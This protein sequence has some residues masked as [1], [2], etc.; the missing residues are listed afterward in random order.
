MEQYA[1]YI[2][3]IGIKVICFKSFFQT[4]DFDRDGLTKLKKAIKAIHNSGN[5]KFLNAQII[6]I[7]IL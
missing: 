4:L 7:L 6:S 3:K 5:G 2:L 1:I